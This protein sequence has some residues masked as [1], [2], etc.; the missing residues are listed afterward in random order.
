MGSVQ[1]QL[2]VTDRARSDVLTERSL[3]R[4]FEVR[5]WSLPAL[6]GAAH[7]LGGS[8]NDAYV[9]VLAAGLGRYHAQ[10]GSDV[11]TLRLAMPVST[12]TQGDSVSTN[13]FA[14]AR[15]L[16]PIQPAHDLAAL[17]KDVHER[18][19]AAKRESALSAAGGL[20]AVAS[21]LPTSLLV[22]FT[23]V[24]TRT[25][26]FAAS[27]LRGSPAPLFLAGQAITANYPFG[28]RTGTPLNVT[29][30]SYCDDLHL[31]FNI[32]P[33]A[34]VDVEAFMRDVDDAHRD[35]LAYG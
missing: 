10:L 13:A 34:I 27:N 22:S 20:A 35:I 21:G 1:R 8:L 11:D 24:Q 33:A 29:L 30:L 17:F 3:R 4:W 12:R 26:D 18:L 6:H 2:L 23:R 31:G 19:D 5:A 28:P 15:V 9:T 32:D 25:I 16:V 14:P 7:N